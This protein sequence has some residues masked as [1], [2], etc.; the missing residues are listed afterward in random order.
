MSHNSP[1]QAP[2]EPSKIR[3]SAPARLAPTRQIDANGLIAVAHT[4]KLKT[5]NHGSRKINVYY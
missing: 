4:S 5:P 2:G 1:H 3:P